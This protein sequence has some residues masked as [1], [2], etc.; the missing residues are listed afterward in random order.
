MLGFACKPAILTSR[1]SNPK[2]TQMHTISHNL[3]QKETRDYVR[4]TK[5]T[6]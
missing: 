2:R 6:T 5:R 3:G 4:K 1:S